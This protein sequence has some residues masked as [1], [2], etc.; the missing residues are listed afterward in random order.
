M[1]LFSLAVALLSYLIGSVP[2]GYLV[3]RWRGVDVLTAGSGNIGAT[4]VGRLLGRPFGILVFVLD[5]LKGALPVLLAMIADPYANGPSPAIAGVIAGIAAFLGHLFPLFLG[6]RGGKG[7]ATG[8]GIVLVLLPLPTLAALFFWL[9]IASATRYVSLPCCS[10]LCGWRPREPTT[11][12]A[13][14]SPSSA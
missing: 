11:G 13:S 14:S 4:N 12:R 3:G 5:F 8:A 9:T 10:V 1:L 2:F 6:F 7:V